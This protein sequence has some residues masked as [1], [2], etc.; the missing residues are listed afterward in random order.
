M[1]ILLFLLPLMFLTAC[2]SKLDAERAREFYVSSC[3][4][5]RTVAFEQLTSQNKCNGINIILAIFVDDS[6]LTSASRN[7][8][9]YTLFRDKKGKHDPKG[10][11]NFREPESGQTLAHIVGEYGYHADIRMLL[12]KYSK[13][14]AFLLQDQTREN[15]FHKL[16]RNKILTRLSIDETCKSSASIRDMVHQ[17]NA[18]GLTP[19]DLAAS[20]KEINKVL[21]LYGCARTQ[22]TMAPIFADYG[23]EL[24][25]NRNILNYPELFDYTIPYLLEKREMA[26][27]NFGYKT[28]RWTLFELYLMSP[29]FGSFITEDESL[30]QSFMSDEEIMNRIAITTHPDEFGRVDGYGQ[31]TLFYYAASSLQERRLFNHILEKTNLELINRRG[32]TIYHV[33]SKYGRRKELK[34]V[35]KKIPTLQ[36]L[37]VKDLKGQ[38]PLDVCTKETCKLL[39][40]AIRV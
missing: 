34:A 7:Y 39:K 35:L 27:P 3:P 31:S 15:V 9:L 2:D 17:R 36:L 38:T 4:E 16:A 19:V 30:F 23:P 37:E 14:E 1:K 21:D 12:D 11:E 8:Y 32:E 29:T 18:F 20:K 26:N 6:Y 33:M 5:A 10:M 24:A 40:N 25:F 28:D 13:Y 22:Q